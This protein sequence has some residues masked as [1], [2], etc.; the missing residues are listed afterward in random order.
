MGDSDT[1]RWQEDPIRG[2][3]TDLLEGQW[4]GRVAKINHLKDVYSELTGDEAAEGLMKDC[5]V[6][7]ERIENETYLFCV[8]CSRKIVEDVIRMSC[9]WITAC[10]DCR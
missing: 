2:L 8:K 10:K 5:D 3:R 1:N 7:L 9:P 4:K 6:A